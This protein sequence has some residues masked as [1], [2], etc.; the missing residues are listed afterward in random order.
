MAV[1]EHGAVRRIV[2]CVRVDIPIAE[3]IG[4]IGTC[5]RDT[6]FGIFAGFGGNRTIVCAIDAF[7]VCIAGV[8]GKSWAFAHTAFNGFADF[9]GITGLC[10]EGMVCGTEDGRIS[11]TL[12]G[13]FP[14]FTGFACAIDAIRCITTA[15]GTLGDIAVDTSGWNVSG[16]LSAVGGRITFIADADAVL[17]FFIALAG[18]W[19]GI[20]ARSLTDLVAI[21][22]VANRG[23]AGGTLRLEDAC[24]GNADIVFGSTIAIGIASRCATGSLNTLFAVAACFAFERAVSFT[25]LGRC[26]VDTAGFCGSRIT[27][28]TVI[29]ETNGI[30]SAECAV[31]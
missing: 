25:D 26:T 8:T 9:I 12:N 10:R 5:A 11:G 22:I 23:C 3:I 20:N 6:C 2:T 29:I 21:I 24:A 7:S 19:C 15:C 16:T 1:L 30:D 18:C 27:L 13:G 17:A 28:C 4:T 31:E 14:V